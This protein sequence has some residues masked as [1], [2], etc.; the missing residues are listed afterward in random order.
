[1]AYYALEPEVAGGF[2]PNTVFLDVK[3]RPPLI[4]KFNYE[5]D[6]WLGDPL[7]E[8]VGCYIVMETLREKIG[9]VQASGVSFGPVEISKS[10]QFQ[11]LYPDVALPSF[12]W[13]QVTGN[14]GQDDFGLS[15]IASRT[16]LVVSGQILK[17]LEEAGMSHCEIAPFDKGKTSE[18]TGA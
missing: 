10:G 17:I 4:A 16:R 2:G 1:M 9:T 5:F 13:L 18:E 15:R 3:A 12:L 8:A 7:L 11:D 6:V 14:A